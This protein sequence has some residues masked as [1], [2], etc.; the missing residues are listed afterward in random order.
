MRGARGQ[1][2]LRVCPGLLPRLGLPEGVRSAAHTFV[3]MDHGL[4]F[5]LRPTAVLVLLMVLLQ[6]IAAH[7]S[8]VTFLAVACGGGEGRKP[9]LA[10][11]PQ[12]CESDKSG[13]NNGSGSKPA[14][15]R[16][17]TDRRCHRAQAPWE[18]RARTETRRR[19][20]SS[21]TALRWHST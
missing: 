5:E 19:R 8:L 3:T 17:H 10:D 13:G 15:Q 7:C 4:L 11:F 1:E 16:G 9:K 18:R 20:Q 14:T 21:S 6:L 12:L 2:R